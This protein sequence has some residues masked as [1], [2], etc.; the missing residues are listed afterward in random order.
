MNLGAIYWRFSAKADWIAQSFS[1]AASSPADGRCLAAHSL[2]REDAAI[3]LQDRWNAFCR[4]LVLLSWRGEVRTLSG[5]YI[6]RREGNRTREAA[7]MA[8]RATFTGRSK[9]RAEW[10]PRW[11]SPTDAIDAAGRLHVANLA[12]ISSGLGLTPSP[13]DELRAIRN[14][15]AHRGRESSSRLRICLGAGADASVAH[16]HLSQTTLGGATQFEVW[17]SQLDSMARIAVL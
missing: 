7:L 8:L 12:S 14:H 10:E 3:Q 5:T 4:E 15:F 17:A 16:D 11:F 2:S 9:K 6:P 1:H 13:L